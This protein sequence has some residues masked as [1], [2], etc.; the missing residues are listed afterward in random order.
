MNL[1]VLDRSVGLE[2]EATASNLNR[3]PV[4]L[5]QELDS[6]IKKEPFGGITLDAGSDQVEIVTNPSKDLRDH[7][8]EFR[9]LHDRTTKLKEGIKLHFVPRRPANLPKAT[10]D[11]WK[12]PRLKAL[13]D[14]LAR[15]DEGGEYGGE[16]LW[17]GDINAFHIHFGV[18][19]V[20][21]D[22]ANTI[23]CA[24][25]AAAPAILEY[26]HD[27]FKIPQVSRNE[28]WA[29]FARKERLPA[30]RWFGEF[31]DMREFFESIPRLIAPV[32]DSCNKHTGGWVEDCVQLQNFQD[33]AAA[34]TC[35]WT[36]R[37]RPAYNTVEF[38]PLPAFL[39]PRFALHAVKEID[40]W[41]SETLNS[42]GSRQFASFQE[43]TNS[44]HIPDFKGIALPR[45]EEE[46]W[47]RWRQF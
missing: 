45:S 23:C 31:S 19:D 18:S 16:V 40:G 38:R 46:W 15:S 3:G 29:R 33:P 47:Q 36:V 44:G 17:S 14:A 21:T 2:F 26:V 20:C 7:Y 32:S 6:P 13:R 22:E 5:L 34:G 25:N 35:W 28:V 41:L 30:P 8:G 1:S 4:C 39:N 37:P 9:D 12:K 43:A 10:F 11:D 42:I 24:L 27:R